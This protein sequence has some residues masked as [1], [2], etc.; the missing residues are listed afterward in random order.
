DNTLGRRDSLVS[1]AGHP[2]AEMGGNLAWAE[3]SMG[4][5]VAP[6]RPGARVGLYIGGVGLLQPQHQQEARRL[7]VGIAE[8][9]Q[10]AGLQLK[11]A[12]RQPRRLRPFVP[13]DHLDEQG[14]IVRASRVGYHAAALLPFE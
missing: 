7:A 11:P 10:S 9:H 4:L 13:F 2:E 12:R 6:S 3:G 14:H 1:V 8:Y 5:H